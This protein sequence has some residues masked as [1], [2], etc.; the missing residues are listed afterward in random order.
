N[1]TLASSVRPKHYTFSLRDALPISERAIRRWLNKGEMPPDLLERIAK[2]LN[3][4]P[5]Y[6]SGVCNAEANQIKNA[7]LRSLF[8]SHL[9]L[10]R[11]EVHTSE[12]QSRFALVCRLLLLRQ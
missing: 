11:S 3:V 5:D 6:L 12:L 1:H 7:Y 8:H 9:N 4:H 2:F 10:E